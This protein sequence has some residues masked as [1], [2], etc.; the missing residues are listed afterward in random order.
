[1]P[2]LDQ[3][4]WA[5]LTFLAAPAILTNASTILALGTSNRLARASDRARAASRL[6]LESK[7]GESGESKESMTD[8][9][10]AARRTG[11]LIQALR[12]FYLG[13]GCF[14]AATC[15]ALLG[16]LATFFEIHSLD[17]VARVLAILATLA[18]VGSLVSGTLRLV[19]E[20][21][22]ALGS[23]DRQYAAIEKWRTARQGPPVNP[24]L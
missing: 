21:R 23:I 17:M 3:N 20:T 11:M 18:G 2:T 8:F 9:D 7:P 1:M 22:V 19:A 13:A 15:V 4:P 14:A 5:V 24:G 6:I 12:R 10:A 16:G